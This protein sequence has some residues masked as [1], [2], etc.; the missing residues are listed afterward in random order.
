MTFRLTLVVFAVAGASACRSEKMPE[1]RHMQDALREAPTFAG[2][3]F[4]SGASCAAPAVTSRSRYADAAAREQNGPANVVYDVLTQHND[5][6][7]SGA[8][9]HEDVLTP[10]NVKSA[11]FGYLGST[12]V[13][14]KI[15]AQPL[16][17]EKA[18]VTCGAARVRN[19]NIVYVATLENIVYA[20]DVDS[21]QVCWST[22]RL[23][24][25]QDGTG[26]LG[27]DTQAEGGIRVGIVSTPV[28]DLAKSVLYA[29]S[30]E[31]TGTEV[32]FWVNTIDT[33][34]GALLARVP[35]TAEANIGCGVHA[36]TPD[37]HNNRP[38]LLLVQDK[39][40]LAFGSTRGRTA[41]STITDSSSASTSPIR[42][43][44]SACRACSAP[45]QRLQAR[46]SGC[47][48]AGWPRTAS[49]S[50]S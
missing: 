1:P 23:G 3:T 8:A 11:A 17:V 50:T 32:R 13:K 26:L 16:Y 31:W 34:D 10:A 21:R 48:A 28:I 22:P 47:R 37:S 49:P 27:I 41:A 5:L 15:Y 12:P 46:E 44:R 36:F 24:C 6:A 4:A 30:R 29:V 42:R 25:G 20:I 18:A 9:T 35:V 2:G 33:R 39:L 19:A 40:F 38:G 14:G 45:H 43:R 7:R